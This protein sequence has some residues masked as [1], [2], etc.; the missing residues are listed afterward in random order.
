MRNRSMKLRIIILG[1]ALMVTAI[2]GG[3]AFAERPKDVKLT[4]DGVE[5]NLYTSAETVKE[6]LIE[7]GFDDFKETKVSTDLANPIVDNMEI[8]L[9]TL[10]HVSFRDGNTVK[11]MRTYSNTVGEL[12]EETGTEY[13]QDDIISPARLG[14]IKDG[15]KV[16]LDH[17]EKVT[18]TKTVE[19]PFE[20]ENKES[21]EILKG[22]KKIEKEGVVGEKR[23]TKEITYKNGEKVEEKEL[24]AEITK[25]AVNQV[26]VNGSKEVENTVSGK[27]TTS[28]ISLREFI[29]RG[30]VNWGGYKFTYYSQRVLPGK[31][32]KIPG[33]HVS[34]SGFVCDGNG[35]IVLAGSA[36]KGT[37]FSTPFGAPGKIYDRGTSGRHLDVYVR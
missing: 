36:V 5:I 35:Y 7:A 10:K 6:A 20:I 32:L 22:Q 31:G 1:L 24:N 14:R 4:A 9:R 11:V 29:N 37:V 12:I 27:S 26:V 17:I 13:D 28:K 18:E 34:A 2:V 16:S 21:N 33:R 3:Y 23:V 25:E 30:V 8:E 15:E 19:I